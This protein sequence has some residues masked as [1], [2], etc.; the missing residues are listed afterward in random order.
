MYVF[1]P[2]PFQVLARWGAGGIGQRSVKDCTTI[3]LGL[4]HVL[5]QALPEVDVF[6]GG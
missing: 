5:L 3:S 2:Q 6:T 1:D 4:V